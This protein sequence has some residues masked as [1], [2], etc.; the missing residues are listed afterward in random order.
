MSLIILFLNSVSTIAQTITLD[1]KKALV[2]ENFD[3]STSAWTIAANNE[4]FFIVQDGEYILNRK[5]SVAPFAIVCGFENTALQYKLIT[6]LKLDKAS[7][8]LNSMGLL[9]QLQPD[10]KG[11]FLFEV[12][13]QKQFRI[14]EISG[15]GYKF[16]S[17]DLKGEG[18]VR[19]NFIH[20]N[21]IANLIELR[22]M[23]GVYDFYINTNFA[24]TCKNISYKSGNFGFVIGPSSKA[25]ID[26]FYLLTNDSNGNVSAKPEDDISILAESI[27]NLKT[28]LNNVSLE[29][30]LLI[31][32]I[33]AMK[34]EAKHFNQEKQ[35]LTT[36]AEQHQLAYNKLLL[37]ND[38][39][40]RVNNDL[41][42]YK[43]IFDS[44]NT[45]DIVINLS[46]ALK[47][48]KQ[49]TIKLQEQL[50]LIQKQ[51]PVPANTPFEQPKTKPSD[52]F[53]LPK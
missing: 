13:G 46:K 7:T 33:E 9:F 27:I 14:R 10:K 18:W 16:I 5:N 35:Q 38:S 50:D 43:A 17:G 51:Q 40:I 8:E 36:A 22:F 20:Q 23:E 26:F 48:E 30:E 4:N 41:N 19:S 24:F 2:K 53:N 31:N 1:F 29:N 12:N 32:T 44:N 49:K 21:G 39:L 15:N 3:S 45:G 28:L 25:K 37:V 11:G 6:S 42:K 34:Q 47:A 52:N